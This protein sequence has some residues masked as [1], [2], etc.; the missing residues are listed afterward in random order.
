MICQYLRWRYGNVYALKPPLGYHPI[1]SPR[2]LWWRLR[3]R[4]QKRLWQIDCW[5]FARSPMREKWL[6]NQRPT[7][8][9]GEGR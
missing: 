1:Y 9:E 8:G 7:A 3:Y 5:L 6:G 2:P 4:V